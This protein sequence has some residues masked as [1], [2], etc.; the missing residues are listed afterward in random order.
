MSRKSLSYWETQETT[1]LNCFVID[2]WL[3]LKIRYLSNEIVVLC[4]DH[5]YPQPE[6]SDVYLSEHLL[7]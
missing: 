5:N 1:V 6:G 3:L 7:A 2:Y 4:K